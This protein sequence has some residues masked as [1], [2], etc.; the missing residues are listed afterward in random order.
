MADA[1][2]IL[3]G[4]QTLPIALTSNGDGTYSV[5]TGAE[6]TLDPTNLA[7]SAKQD[8]LK[9]VIGSVADAAWSGTGDGTVIA[10]L[11]AIAVNTTP[12]P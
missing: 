12:T 1:S 11:K 3:P 4:N 9:A 5:T 2:L 8:S 6:I 10:I 7:T